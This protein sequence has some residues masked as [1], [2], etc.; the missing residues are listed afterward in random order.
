MSFTKEELEAAGW[1]NANLLAEPRQTYSEWMGGPVHGAWSIDGLH[2]T[3]ELILRLALAHP[4]RAALAL[5]EGCEVLHSEVGVIVHW[6]SKSGYWHIMVRGPFE[7]TME[8][9]VDEPIPPEFD[10]ALARARRISAAWQR[11]QAKDGGK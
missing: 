2:R 10:A 11:I 1:E 3:H 5:G 6:W 9:T 4:E 8:G 7:V